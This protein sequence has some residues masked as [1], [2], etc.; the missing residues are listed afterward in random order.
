[1]ERGDGTRPGAS[2]KDDPPPLG[3]RQGRKGDDVDRGARRHHGKQE[4]SHQGSVG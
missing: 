4:C 2:D 3:P 1:M